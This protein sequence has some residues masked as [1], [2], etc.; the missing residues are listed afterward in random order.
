MITPVFIPISSGEGSGGPTPTWGKIVLG[1]L[2]IL[3]FVCFLAM[4]D[5]MCNNSRIYCKVRFKPDCTYVVPEG[6][7]IVYD[8]VESE[9]AIRVLRHND[10]F[11][12]IDDPFYIDETFSSIQKPTLFKDS[13]M[14]KAV[15]KKYISQQQP[16][17]TNFK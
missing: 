1:I 11:L 16:T 8:T 3:L 4:W 14:A 6:Y 10:Y 5:G 12:R 13:C 7:R 9:Y 17:I 15:L 2:F